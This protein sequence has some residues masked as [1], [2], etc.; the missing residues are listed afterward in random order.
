MYTPYSIYII[1]KSRTRNKF[2]PC[3]TLILPI[4]SNALTV[5]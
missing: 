5:N 2:I 4:A 3:P 1:K